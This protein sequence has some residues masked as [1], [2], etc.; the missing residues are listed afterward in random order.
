MKFVKEACSF[1]KGEVQ[2][3]FRPR[4]VLDEPGAPTLAVMRLNVGQEIENHTLAKHGGRFPVKTVFIPPHSKELFS[5]QVAVH[6]DSDT[7]FCNAIGKQHPKIRGGLRVHDRSSI[8]DQVTRSKPLCE[9]N[10]RIQGHV[11]IASDVL[12]RCELEQ[13]LPIPTS[14][15]SGKFLKGVGIL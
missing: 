13:L 15:A 6:S 5:A 1:C 10:I 4:S 12:G 14:I 8:S 11:K 7:V 9:D 2:A 3:V